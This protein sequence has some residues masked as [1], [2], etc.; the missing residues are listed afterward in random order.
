MDQGLRYDVAEAVM[1]VGHDNLSQALV[2]GQLLESTRK[3]SF[4]SFKLLV[5]TAVR[6]KRLAQKAAHEDVNESFFMLDIEKRSFQ[7]FKSVQDQCQFTSLASWMSLNEAL[8]AYFDEVLVMDKD[9]KIQL[10][11]LAFLKKLDQFYLN[12]AD[13]EKIVLDT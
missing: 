13:F 6:V 5:D 8:T 12:V 7:Q 11:R 1:H 4:D 2:M 3:T 10:N 9:Q